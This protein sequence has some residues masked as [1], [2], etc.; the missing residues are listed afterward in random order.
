[1]THEQQPP[2]VGII[3]PVLIA[4][5]TYKSGIYDGDTVKVRRLGSKFFFPVRIIDCWCPE[6]IIKGKAKSL[7][8][9][10][11][12][13]IVKAAEAARESLVDLLHMHKPLL[14]HLPVLSWDLSELITMS[15]VLG[16]LWAGNY[17]V[18]EWMVEHGH[19]TRT[20]KELSERGLAA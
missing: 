10:Q 14:F 2:P 13:R 9:R 11:Q 17:S 1:M 19:A 15:R 8:V 4:E 20:K 7:P 12:K 18:A 5:E 3:F 16:N 6:L